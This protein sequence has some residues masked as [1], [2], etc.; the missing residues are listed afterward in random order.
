MFGKR[1]VFEV[2][3]SVPLVGCIA[4]GLIDRGTNVI[5][6]RPVSTCPLS[7][8]FCSTNA[9]P[10]S[11]V[12]QTEYVVPLE[13]L[14]EGFRRLVS[15]KGGHDVEAHIDTVGDPLTYPDLVELV[16]QLHQTGGVRTVSLQTHGS[17]LTE[18]LLNELS[19]AGLTRINLSI[20]ALDPETAK[21]LADTE[22][23]DAKR[24]AALAKYTVENT[25]ISL[26]MAPVWVPTVNDEEIPKII[27]FALEIGAGKN[28]PPLGIQKY[29]VHR[30]GRKAR[31]V[32][33]MSWRRFYDQ[34]RA[35]ERLFGV[36]L[37]L[38]PEDFG[39]HKRPM[40]PVPYKRLEKVRVK[41][42]A[43]G[44]LKGEKLAVTLRGDR[45]VTLVNADEVP[46]GAKVKARVLANK[47]N[48]YV[49]E[50]VF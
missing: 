18:K 3:E 29:E 6:V 15:F 5:Q 27:R 19:E 43:P 39:V 49:A 2:D 23:Y 50:V 41:V 17:I 28:F 22:W 24:V 47:H 7:C 1:E 11:R 16:A 4:F 20:D 34:L 26:L 36:K 42:V 45:T 25:S 37:V 40:L 38:K 48:I 9:G 12:R 31:G 21:K 33:A 46:V 13:Y 10:K 32:K 35:W 8:V 44:W 30:Y 14:V